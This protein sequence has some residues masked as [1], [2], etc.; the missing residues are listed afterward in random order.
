MGCY[1]KY[2][3]HEKWDQSLH[4]YNLAHN[5]A[6]VNILIL[7][8]TLE[9]IVG[10][11]PPKPNHGYEEGHTQAKITTSPRSL[12]SMLWSLASKRSKLLCPPFE[13]LEE[14]VDGLKVEYIDF[15]IATKAF[16]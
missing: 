4:P 8:T 5:Q 13:N 15:T 12:P 2:S 11:V 9:G 3:S 1:A 6:I 10:V 16:I 7:G 14:M